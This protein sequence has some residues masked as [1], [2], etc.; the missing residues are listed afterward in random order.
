MEFSLNRHEIYNMGTFN[1]YLLHNHYLMQGT[2]LNVHYTNRSIRNKINL[3]RGKASVERSDLIAITESWI[4]TED[5]HFLPK[6][7][8]KKL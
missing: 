1:I 4:N 7:R 8:D 5:R 2:D 6:L 3:F